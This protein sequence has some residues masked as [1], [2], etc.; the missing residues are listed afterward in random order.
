MRTIMLNRKTIA[1]AS[2]IFVA[3]M[4]ASA[5]IAEFSPD[6]V[7][8][9]WLLDD[10]NGAVAKDASGNGHL[11]QLIGN[12]QWVAG[13]FGGALDFDGDDRVD[14]G[15]ID[16]VDGFTGLTALAWC[17]WDG[18]DGGLTAPARVVSKQDPNKGDK[19]PFSLGS[20][21]NAHKLT[22]WIH[23][24]NWAGVHSVTNIDDG[25]WHHV[26]G[27]YDGNS[28][29]VYVDGVEEAES[30]IGKVTGGSTPEHVAIGSDGFGREF[31]KGVIDEVALFSVPLTED[32]ISGI[33]NNGLSPLSAVSEIGKLATTWGRLKSR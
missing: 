14:C 5:S 25:E 29:R 23:F 18:G 15:D 3:M 10:G 19:G 2:T 27:T 4:L 12:P 1:F 22:L 32:D 33:M 13:K 8:A 24:G 7:I 26:A 17:R 31:W 20:G 21:W 16:G 30:N 28:L 11:G 6:D 9:M